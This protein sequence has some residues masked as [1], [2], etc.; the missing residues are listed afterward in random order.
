MAEFDKDSVMS[1]SIAVN[2]ADWQTLLD[3]ATDKEYI[4]ADV[5][6]NGV[7]VKNVGIRAK[8]NSSL[9]SVA[10]DEDSDRYSFKIKFD[11]YVKGQTWLGLDQLV[12]N[13]NYSDAT[14][15]KEYLSYDIMSFIGVD[16]PL[17][18]Y[19]D[20]AVN[21]ESWGF[22]LA[23]EDLEDGYLE[24]VFGGEGALYKPGNDEMGNMPSG[25][26]DGQNR[27][28]MPENFAAGGENAP[29][30]PASGTD[31][32]APDQAN[33]FGGDRGG[34][35]GMGGSMGNMAS[36]G[37]SL[38][39]T[40]D[41]EESYSAIFDNDKTK[42]NEADHQR[43]IEALKNLSEGNDL[44]TYVDVDA[45]L[46]YFAA[47]TVVVNLDSYVSNMGHNYILYE[48]GGQISMLPW[49]YNL[50]F[51]GFQSG[52]ASDVV[53]FP[54]DTPV[55]GVSMED[56]PILSKLLEVP[57]YL[58]KYHEYLQK[59]V[60][61]YFAD[62]KFEQKVDELDALIGEHIQNDPSAFY[63]YDE[64]QKAIVELEK[65]GALRGESIQG[66]LD[67]T[68]P[69]TTDGQNAQP[70]ALINASSVDLS[71][72]GTQGGDRGMGG[73]FD[74]GQMPEGFTPPGADAGAQSPSSVE[75]A[76]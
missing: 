14:S 4:S 39:Y 16:T 64:Y 71:A 47:H 52:S 29:Q 33:W 3:N 22:Y 43:V 13:S 59:I 70:D 55:S 38:K 18:A 46:R 58:E 32:T 60:E 24:R 51:G 54:I 76:K 37:V 26:A 36:D 27:P 56:R 31:R 23:I 73:G 30:F 62:G 25:G 66:Q 28:S 50:A 49:D 17:Y 5:T 10:R 57:E 53:N 21:G 19:A 6:I 75:T 9:S 48:N 2:A 35:G 74:R 45:V 15:M 40:D 65:L 12:L 61:G 34:P 8:G 42:T 69:S 41:N 44:E 11:E 7:T 72:M 63:T 67:G 20:I 68:I 1:F